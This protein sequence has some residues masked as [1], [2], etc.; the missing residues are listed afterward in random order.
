MKIFGREPVRWVGIIVTVIGAIVATLLGQ[1]VISDALA[2]RI[3]DLTDNL[4]GIAVFLLPLITAEIARRGATSVVQP[5]LEV[6]TPVL[7]EKP[8]GLPEDTPP[9]DAIVALRTDLKPTAP[10]AVP[11]I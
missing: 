2:G 11:A 9:P 8:A 6:G 5:K 1:G 10:G 4:S 7:V 3:T